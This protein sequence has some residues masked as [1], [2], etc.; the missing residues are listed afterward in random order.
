ML[1]KFVRNC[2]FLSAVTFICTV[3]YIY[4]QYKYKTLR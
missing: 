4:L 2:D 1:I 3:I